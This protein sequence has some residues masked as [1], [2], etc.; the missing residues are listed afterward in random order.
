[1]KQNERRAGVRP[2]N[3]FN[4]P[5]GYDEVGRINLL[6]NRRHLLLINSLA[7]GIA[8][9][10]IV[11]ALIARG[12]NFTGSGI[13]MVLLKIVV[14]AAAIFVYIVL[15]ELTHGVFIKKYSGKRAIYGFGMGYACAG[16]NAYFNKKSYIIIALAPVVFWGAV[17]LVLNL[18]LPS[19]W[20]WVVYGV[21]ILNLSGAA[22][23]YYVTYKML[24]IPSDILVRDSGTVM[25]IYAPK[26]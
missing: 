23:D 15:H 16:S 8:A 18:L 1:M 2:P 14:L 21:Q 25:V 12:V 5:A 26:R 17:L 11:A 20:F 9:V 6:V 3:T 7:F 4:L 13:G 22:G 10:L 19:S 24:Q